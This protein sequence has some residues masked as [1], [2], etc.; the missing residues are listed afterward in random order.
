[1]CINFITDVWGCDKSL[2]Y[3]MVTDAYI[4][5]DTGIW[6]RHILTYY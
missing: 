4:L 6:L 5:L 3:Y 2:F 1:M